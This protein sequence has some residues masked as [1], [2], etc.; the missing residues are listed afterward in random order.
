MKEWTKSRSEVIVTYGRN[1]NIDKKAY[2][3]NSWNNSNKFYWLN[4]NNLNLELLGK[5]S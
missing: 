5:N 1:K 3:D 4:N 2:K